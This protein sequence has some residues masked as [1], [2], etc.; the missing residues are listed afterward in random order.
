[1]IAPAE[2]Q[3]IILY[4]CLSTLF[5]LP[6]HD[7]RIP[8]SMT[9]E[10]DAG[11]SRLIKQGSE[12]QE[13]LVRESDKVDQTKTTT[14]NDVVKGSNL[15]ETVELNGKMSEKNFIGKQIRIAPY[16]GEAQM[17]AIMGLID[18]E[19][20]EPYTVY[21]YRYFL[22]QWPELCFLAHYSPDPIETPNEGIPIG[23]VIGKLEKHLKGNR[24]MRGYI[25]MVSI[26]S[27]FRGKGIAT[28]LL[29]TILRKMVLLGA[30]EI[31][32]ETEIDNKASLQLYEKLGFIREK[33]LFNF[34][35]NG[36]DCF[37]LIAE[38]PKS[39]WNLRPL[40]STTPPPNLSSTLYPF[41]QQPP[42]AA[43]L[44]SQQHNALPAHAFADLR[45]TPPA[46]PTTSSNISQ[47][48]FFQSNII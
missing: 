33:R 40:P 46:I 34:Y 9:E 3:I 4:S 20:S 10:Q 38:I 8:F 48:G 47:R 30:Q 22:N 32:L 44:Q 25:G 15:A 42:S 21:T 41:P 36:K 19:L 14:L 2:E 29:Q 5:L 35:L 28:S 18:G 31:V 7:L 27:D 45:I 17:Q 12:A 23:V 16:E 39:F 43:I 6:E 1:L 24:F 11:P 13:N 37:R 26:R